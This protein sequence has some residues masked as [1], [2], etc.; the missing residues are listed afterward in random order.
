[1][2]IVTGGLMRTRDANACREELVQNVNFSNINLIKIEL[3]ISS[4]KNGNVP[5]HIYVGV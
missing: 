3:E 1:M 5:L 4:V 2:P